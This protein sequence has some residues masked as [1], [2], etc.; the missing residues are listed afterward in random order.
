MTERL[1]RQRFYSQPLHGYQ[2]MTALSI[3]RDVTGCNRSSCADD[4]RTKRRGAAGRHAPIDIRSGRDA[5]VCW[6]KPAAKKRARAF[7]ILRVSGD[8]STCAVPCLNFASRVWLILLSGI[9]GT[10]VYELMPA[11]PPRLNVNGSRRDLAVTNMVDFPYLG[12]C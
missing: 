6:Q 5:Q 8:D 9:A 10:K 7:S 4:R 1:L 11:I 2:E 3:C 12:E